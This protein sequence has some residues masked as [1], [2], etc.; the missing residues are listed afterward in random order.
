[1]KVPKD[2]KNIDYAS[3]IF[4]NTS[5]NIWRAKEVSPQQVSGISI[6]IPVDLRIGISF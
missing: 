1:M 5:K 2:P 6:L 4:W 3:K